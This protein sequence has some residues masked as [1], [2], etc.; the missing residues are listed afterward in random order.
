VIRGLRLAAV[1]LLAAGAS[2]SQGATLTA[3]VTDIHDGDTISIRVRTKTV[4]VRLIYID[5]PELAQPWGRQA[6]RSLQE[7]V[8]L[9][10]VRVRTKGKDKYSRTLGEVVRVRDGLDVNLEQVRRGMAWAYTRG[11]ARPA[12]DAAELA[13]HQ[14]R[15]GLWQDARPERPSNFRKKQRERSGRSEGRSA[16]L[17]EP[18]GFTAAGGRR[19]EVPPAGRDTVHLEGFAA[20]PEQRYRR[21][22]HLLRSALGQVAHGLARRRT[23]GPDDAVAPGDGHVE[24]AHLALLDDRI[25]LESGHVVLGHGGRF[26]DGGVLGSGNG[27]ADGRGGQQARRGSESN[28]LHGV[29]PG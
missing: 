10:E 6:R 3:R 2:A 19:L 15:I 9:E 8:R 1:A 18:L 11:A 20:Q 24:A 4:A 25:A 21:E 27:G 17:V 7:L 26:L 22:C 12:Y 13:A 28:R 5:A 16:G 23:L 14:A 29:S